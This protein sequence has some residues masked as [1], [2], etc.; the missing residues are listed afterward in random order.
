[1]AHQNA[2]DIIIIGAGPGGITAAIYAK[3]YNAK[4]LLLEKA[5]P[6]GKLNVYHKLENY[7]GV[8]KI[9]A[10]ELG[11]EMYEQLRQQG[12]EVTY[13]DVMAL[14]K[15]KDLFKL[16]TDHGTHFSKAVIIASGTSDKKLGIPGET[17]LLGRGVSF[18]ASCDGAFFKG[19]PVAVVGGN[20]QAVEESI[21]LADIVAKVTLFVP[22]DTLTARVDLQERLKQ[23]K[24]V[25][26]VLNAVPIQ[27]VGDDFVRGIKV[28]TPQEKTFEAYAVFPLIG[29][30]P[31]T[32]FN[33]F[34]ETMDAHGFIHVDR[35]MQTTI[36]GLFAIGDVQAKFLR[37]VVSAAGEGATAALMASRFVKRIDNVQ[38]E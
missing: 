6:G 38:E 27:V 26:I 22:G 10:Q 30:V 3:R 9:S 35:N 18:C 7:P 17:E 28:R 37:Q 29:S 11:L 34:K 24:N 16:E 14:S 36:P 31:N 25:T 12:V 5:M 20:S 33:P 15:E 21:F 19:K 23:K 13:G 4:L 32:S 2:Y 8:Y 1:M